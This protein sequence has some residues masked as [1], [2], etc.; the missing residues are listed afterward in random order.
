MPF[1][2][3]HD[4]FPDLAERETRTLTILDDTK[5]PAGDYALIEMYC[6]EPGCDCRRVFFWVLSSQTSQVEA[7]IAYGWENTRFYAQWMGDGDPQ[8]AKALKG[9]ILN[10]GS[11]QAAFAPA[12]LD[13]VKNVVVQDEQYVARLKTHYAMFRETIGPKRKVQ[14]PRQKKSRRPRLTNAQKRQRRRQ[15]S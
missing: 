9:P 14:Q 2:P 10:P 4:T 7:I 11:P 6:D 5:L 8:M 3:F 12:L 1:V 13:L 15:R